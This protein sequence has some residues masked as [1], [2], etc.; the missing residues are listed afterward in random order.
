MGEQKKRMLA[1]EWYLPDD[2]ELAAE[3]LRR[4]E[5][6]A[7]YE[8]VAPAD[9]ARREEI[10][11]ELLGSV[12]EGVRVRAPFRCDFGYNITIGSG[13]FVNFGAVFLDTG[14]I[15]IGADVQIGPNVQ[16]LTPVHE[17][18]PARRREGWEKGVP[19]TIGD[20]VWL[21]GGVIVCPGVTIGADT[22]V[23]A[24]SVVTRDLPPRVLA[25]GNPARVVRSL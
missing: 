13:T 20:N 25:V 4:A 21:G 12:G 18:D 9:A 8:A 19:V 10:L 2:P 14:R 16:V 15:T 17:M 11:R 24:G 22:V 7:A 23:G 1:G 3:S 6:C 5:L